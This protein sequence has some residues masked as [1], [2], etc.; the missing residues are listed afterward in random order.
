MRLPTA[1]VLAAGA[2]F[3]QE[4]QSGFQIDATVSAGTEFSRQLS[5][6]PRGGSSWAGGMRAV[7]YPMWRI[8]RHWSFTSAVQLHSRPYFFEEFA[9]QGYG[10][11]A[12]IL[13]AQLAYSLTAKDRAFSLRAGQMTSAFGSYLLR[14]D[15]FRNPLIDAPLSYG[16]YGK[17]VTDLG[18]MGVEADASYHRLDF[19][20]QFT[21]S[22]PANRRSIFDHDQYGDWTGGIGVTIAQGV[23][24]GVSAYR[25][26]YLDRQSR[27]FLPH[28]APP[29]TLPATGYSFEFEA[30]RGYWNF[31]SEVQRFQ[32]AYTAIPTFTEKVSYA[33]LKRTLSPRWYAA[34]RVNRLTAD[35]GIR[36]TTYETVLGFRPGAFQLLKIGYE[37]QSGPATP[38]A[39]GNVFA[40][41]FVTSLPALSL[42][43]N[44]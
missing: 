41:Q 12:D 39:L 26:P 19:R 14:Y 24:A 13:Q 30:A 2:L 5:A 9:T 40:V 32:F 37:R 42:A 3:G 15:D 33:E 44:N 8:S 31:N 18:L 22:S 1:I 34:I 23:R 11:K 10:F 25:G 27:F 17:G 36:E 29:R 43:R 35:Y 20:A 38:G 6:A 7:F 16:Y 4:T 21:N 28:E